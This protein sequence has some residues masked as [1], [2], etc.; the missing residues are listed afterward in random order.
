MITPPLLS[1]R[2]HTNYHKSIVL[3]F[4]CAKKSPVDFISSVRERKKKKNIQHVSFFLLSFPVS[5]EEKESNSAEFIGVIAE[6]R[7]RTNASAVP[8]LALC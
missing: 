4:K 6:I 3:I 7:S 8:L 5:V 1:C 2:R